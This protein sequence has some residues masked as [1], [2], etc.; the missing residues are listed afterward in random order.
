MPA[1][2]TRDISTL[3]NV[4]LVPIAVVLLFAAYWAA[5]WQWARLMADPQVAFLPRHPQAEWIRMP[6][7]EGPGTYGKKDFMAA[8]RT[9]FTIEAPITEFTLVVHAFRYADVFIDGKHVSSTSQ[10]FSEWK[11]PL[12]I[13]VGP[14]LRPNTHQLMISV[15]NRTGPPVLLAYSPELGLGTGTDWQAMNHERPE[16]I[17]AITVDAPQLNDFGE[18]MKTAQEAFFRTATL[19]FPVF[20][21]VFLWTLLYDR[22]P[23]PKV[24]WPA[25]AI[26]HWGLLFA[27]ALLALNN[28]V[29]VPYGL[30]FDVDAHVQYFQFLLRKHY[31]PYA[32]QGWQMFQSPL[33]YLVA[34]PLYALISELFS[35]THG[36]LAV[37]V[38]SILCGGLQ[39][40][41]CYLVVR[42]FFPDQPRLQV[43]GTLLAGFLPINVYQSQNIG[44]EPMMAL[45]ASVVLLRLFYLT[46]YPAL[47]GTLRALAITGLLLG[48]ALLTKATALLLFPVMGLAILIAS[49]PLQAAW[50]QRAAYIVK[51][52]AVSF[53]AAAAVSAWYY[54]RN[55]QRFEKFFVGGWEE[56]RGYIWWQEPGYRT[57]KQFYTFGESLVHPL[58]SAVHGFWDGLYSTFWLAGF[59]Q[60]PDAILKDYPGWNY[61]FVLASAWWSVFPTLILL[62]GM[63]AIV[64]SP[65]RAL[66]SGQA[67]AVISVGI[68]IAAM[69]MLALRL[70]SFSTIKATYLLAVVTCI[71]IIAARGFQPFLNHRLPRAFVYASMAAWAVTVFA[72]HFVV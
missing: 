46:R 44:N 35:P 14:N 27:W 9:S 67:L 48:A 43:L 37:R 33:Y 16:W 70:P 55:Y 18:K 15:I 63:I 64:W 11:K 36:A 49:F 24:A 65:I 31:I 41:V 61:D 57:A 25:P 52:S 71:A 40:H 7:L 22:M 5:T 60:P 2:A 51:A 12:V 10:D 38:I 30:G 69:A 20:I 3:R 45:L 62:I 28:V 53:G 32:D 21:L 29:K 68:F 54:I 56:L 39:I 58:Y 50:S 8:Y 59:H 47:Y 4:W 23:K 72:A 13:K 66:K 1:A 34:T 26:A 42:E 6:A 19:T 17:N